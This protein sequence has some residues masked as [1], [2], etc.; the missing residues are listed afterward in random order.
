MTFPD[1]TPCLASSDAPI[2]I[3]AML[4]SFIGRQ[5]AWGDTEKG[6]V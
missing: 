4:R 6:F 5:L 3:S 1:I 2:S